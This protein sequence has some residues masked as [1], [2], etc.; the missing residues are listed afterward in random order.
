MMDQRFLHVLDTSLESIFVQSFLQDGIKTQQLKPMG[1]RWWGFLLVIYATSLYKSSNIYKKDNNIWTCP[2]NK[3]Y[4][5]Q[6]GDKSPF[7]IFHK[8]VFLLIDS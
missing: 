1:R 7:F 5:Q 3:K 2:K 8:T 4:L 6:W